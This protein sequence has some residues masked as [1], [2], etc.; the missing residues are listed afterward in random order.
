MIIA[1]DL[2]IIIYLGVMLGVSL[3]PIYLFRKSWSETAVVALIMGCFLFINRDFIWG[4]I[5]AYH[6]T[7]GREWLTL[8]T[9]EWIENGIPLGWNPYMGAGEPIYLY[10]NNFLRAPW[11]FFVWANRVLTIDPHVLFNLFWVSKFF[12]FC[13]GSMLLFMLLY[14]DL[15]TALLPFLALTCGGMFVVNLVQ[16]TGLATIVFFPYIL[17]GI[18]CFFRKKDV[19]GAA[20]AVIFLG[21]A[22]NYYLPHYVFLCTAVFVFFIVL[23]RVKEIPSVLLVL[24][25]R[26]KV[27]FAGLVIA[28]L[29]ASPAL[30]LHTELPNYVSPTRGGEISVSAEDMGEEPSV[31]AALRDY[32]ILLEKAVPFYSNHHAFYFGIIPLLLIPVALM[33]WKK[34]GL[35]PVFVLS[36]VVFVFLGTGND[37]WGYRLLTQHVPKFDMLRHS[38][39]FAH[40][41]SFFLIVL[42]G[43]GF[44]EI[45]KRFSSRASGLKVTILIFFAFMLMFFCSPKINVIRFGASGVLALIFL[46]NA[47]RIFSGRAARYAAGFFYL[48]VMVL[49]FTDL[50]WAYTERR[51]GRFSGRRLAKITA[52]QYPVMRDFYPAASCVKPPDYSPLFFKRASLTHWN[53]DFILFRDR[54][55]DDMLR[56]FVPGAGHEKALGVGGQTVYFTR[57]AVIIPEAVS[58]EQFIDAVY[59]GASGRNKEGKRSVFFSEKDID[60]TAPIMSETTSGKWTIVFPAERTD[61]NSIETRV[62]APEDGFFVRLENFHRGWKAFIDGRETRVYRANYAFQAVRVPKGE[63]TILFKFSTIYPWLFYTHVF[64]V[65]LCWGL[66]NVYLFRPDK[67]KR[68]G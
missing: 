40:F 60:F 44:R 62:N 4:S 1:C 61:P 58:G 46:A 35:I 11:V 33:G 45:L 43:Y 18:I 9:K 32:R 66:F 2:K 26:Y 23:F 50:T 14:D 31:K 53:G 39:G 16:P 21:I 5:G 57:K 29:A 41:V 38:F 8:I 65:I 10:T 3:L 37:F 54:H 63:H 22:M 19:Y 42:A 20:L 28:A 25:N 7:G 59:A 30:F 15:K 13:S 6:D 36:A 68:N 48:L 24:K 49:L 67:Y 47:R 34:D 64:C 12:I 51:D 55:L 17:F 27:V 56:R 52:I